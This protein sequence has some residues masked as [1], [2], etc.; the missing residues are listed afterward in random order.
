MVLGR[1]VLLNGNFLA[2]VN[3]DA[4][5][6][7]LGIELHATYCIPCTISNLDFVHGFDGS[8]FIL[9]DTAQASIGGYAI[10]LSSRQL[11]ISLVRTND[12]R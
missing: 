1:I 5:L 6:D 11:E 12:S 9:E 2:V 4:L 7:W 8:R 10:E 3:I